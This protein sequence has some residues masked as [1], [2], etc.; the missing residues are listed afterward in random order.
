MQKNLR[1]LKEDCEK[2]LGRIDQVLAQ[3][4]INK[5]RVCVCACARVRLCVR[6]CAWVCAGMPV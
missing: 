6:L 2:I 4:K 3:D 5:V 1:V